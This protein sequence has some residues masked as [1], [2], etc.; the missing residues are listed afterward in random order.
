MS[1]RKPLLNDFSPYIWKTTDFGRTWTK[2][3]TGIRNDAYV[4]AVREDPTRKGLLYA[5]TQHGVYLSYDDGANWQ[6]LMLNMPDVPV[7]DVIVEA[8]ELVISSHGRGFWVLDN[9]TPLRQATPEIMAKDVHLFSPPAG[10]RSGA[11][12]TIS[13]LLKNETKRAT[14]EILDSAG[15]VLRTMIADT[16]TGTAA[17][18]RGGRRRGGSAMIPARA[19]INRFEWDLRTEGIVSFPGMILWGAGTAGPAVPPGRYTARLTADNRVTTAPL[20]VKR[21][22]W[23]TD[24]T[25]ADLMAQYQFGRRVRDKATEA[26]K[27]V[28]AVRNMKA[29]L[30]D[31]QKKAADDAALKAAGG[32]LVANA[33]VVE[34]SVYQVRNQSGQ[35]PLN[36][37][38]RVNNRLATLLSMAERGD[39]R[40]TTNMPEIFGILSTQL[41]RYT[42]RLNQIW[43][44]DLV[45]VNKELARLRL[46][47]IDPNCAKPEGCTAVP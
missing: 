21:N 26:N 16:T 33:S 2:I 8:N 10:Y 4:H 25:D 30:A 28:I 39:G 36:F 32:T 43:A 14:L 1:V 47:P 24:V 46:A 3:V 6:S 31:R 11:G 27:A 9:I 17:P 7:S 41:G 12:L 19:G 44:T 40:P 45:A 18:A 42:T 34:D 29:Q 35:D 13:Y 22:P 38:I 20:I 23:I 5:G 15:T 37:P